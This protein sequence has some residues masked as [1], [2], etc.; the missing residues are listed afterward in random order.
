MSDRDPSGQGG[1][2]VV[3]GGGSGIAAF[4]DTT[5]EQ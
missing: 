5:P 4:T 3:T 2:A 1:L